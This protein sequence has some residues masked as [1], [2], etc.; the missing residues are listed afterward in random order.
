MSLSLAL[1]ELASRAD[2]LLLQPA[3][4]AAA[5][6]LVEMELAEYCSVEALKKPF[7][8]FPYPE[9]PNDPWSGLGEDDELVLTRGQTILSVAALHDAL[10]PGVEKIVMILPHLTGLNRDETIRACAWWAMLGSVRKLG[11]HA[12]QW[13]TLLFRRFE[14]ILNE[15][16]LLSTSQPEATGRHAEGQNQQPEMDQECQALVLLFKHPDWTVTEIADHMG[17][18]RQTP[19]KWDKFREAATLS[20]RLKPRGPKEGQPPEGHKTSD[21]RVEAYQDEN[22]DA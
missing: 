16:V 11:D 17:I 6:E 18:S 7:K 4:M 1:D 12:C 21:G 15:R 20:G 13:Y 3:N 10:C 9:D 5:R 22:Q 14:R 19:Y 8:Y 2:A